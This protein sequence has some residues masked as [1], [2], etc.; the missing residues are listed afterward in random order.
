[1]LCVLL[2]TPACSPSPPGDPLGEAIK[3]FGG[4]W[5]VVSLDRSGKQSDARALKDMIVSIEE[6]KFRFE[7]VPAPNELVKGDV[8]TRDVRMEHYILQVNPAKSGDIDLVHT[9]GE[10]QGRARLGLYEF[11][12]GKLMIAL[13]PAGDPRPAKI[14]PGKGVTV[15]VLERQS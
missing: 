6:D 2:G 11:Q 15:F 4:K 1:V 5:K 14:S 13:V 7:E 3:P 9:T 10:N 12:G 8:M